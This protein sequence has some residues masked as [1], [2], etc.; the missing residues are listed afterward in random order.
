MDIINKETE[1]L[2]KLAEENEKPFLKKY[3]QTKEAKIVKEN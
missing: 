3:R 2:A 1:L